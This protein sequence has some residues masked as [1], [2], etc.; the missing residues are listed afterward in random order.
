MLQDTSILKGL[1]NAFDPFRPLPAGDP[2]YVDCREVR[3]DGDILIELGKSIIFSYEE[4]YQLYAG[5][6]GAGK[7]TELLRLANYLEEE[8]Y[9]VIY[10]A[11]DEEDIDPEDAQYTD[12]LL[13]CTRHLLD[14]IKGDPKPLI[15]WL[16]ERWQ[17]LKD[18][19]VELAMTEVS[20][21][22]LKLEAKLAE[23]AKITANVRT[24]PSKRQKIREEVDNHTISLIKALNEFLADAKQRLPK[25][26]LGLVVIADNLDR[27]VPVY[28]AE[29]KRTNHDSIFIDRSE[30]LKA[31]DCH[32]IYT[33]P[34]SMVYSDQGTI[35]EDCFGTVQVLPMIMTKTPDG[36]IFSPG[37]QKLKELIAR[38]INSVDDKLKL[39][40]V[41]EDQTILE[42]LCFMSG[43]HVR[44]LMLLM[45]TVI[46]RT[47]KLPISK[48]SVQRASSELRRTYRN[49][50]AED[51]WKTLATVWKLKRMPNNPQNRKLLFN[52]CILEYRYIDFNGNLKT[53]HD[54]HPL[55]CEIDEFQNALQE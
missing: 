42:Y 46:Q 18:A 49:S 38:R 13:A 14:K 26:C 40:L 51:E 24:I 47:D 1:Y 36:K 7:S 50:I 35:L 21:D 8:K 22:E 2:V 39:S 20:F 15:D 48:G 52:R 45:K 27:I 37:I 30:Q 19:A 34:I 43:G 6:R 32:M 5:H 53:W 10:F 11:A 54:V 25:D 29:S 55:I 31:L 41:F 44:N 16:R 9:R 23:F 33:V 4:T 17:G 12:I 28:N 3:G